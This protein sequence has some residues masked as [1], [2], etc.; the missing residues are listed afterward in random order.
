[1]LYEQRQSVHESP[2]T[3]ESAPMSHTHQNREIDRLYAAPSWVHS[4]GLPVW[5]TDEDGFILFMNRRAET[6]FGHSFDEWRG[7]ACQ[8]VITGHNGDCRL[9]GEHCLTRRNRSE[10]GEI[11]PVRMHLGD[12]DHPREALIVVIAVDSPRG[13]A[14]VH[15]VVEQLPAR[16]SRRHP[17]IASDIKPY[18]GIS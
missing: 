15:C 18:S 1:M 12:D 13:R 7:C 17:F 14:M 11:E 8:L 5:I 4:I 16:R 10:D 6:L 9:C 2:V 3:T